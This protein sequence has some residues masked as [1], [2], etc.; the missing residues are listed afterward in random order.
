M[1]RFLS[2][3]GQT[4]VHP[5]GISKVNINELAQVGSSALGVVGLI[6]EADGGEPDT[7]IIID[8]PSLAKTLFRSGPLADAIRIVFD[9]SSDSRVPGS[10][11]RVIAVKPNQSTQSTGTLNGQLALS[12]DGE[13]QVVLT[14]VDYGVHTDQLTW[15]FEQDVIDT[16]K[17]IATIGEIG[18]N[19]EQIVDIGGT[20]LMNVVFKGPEEEILVYSGVALGT[21]TDLLINDASVPAT[22]TADMYVRII[23]SP[24]EAS[25]VNEVRRVTTV[26]VGT[27]IA[28][29]DADAAASFAAVVDVGAVYEVYKLRLA[30]LQA[31]AVTN[32]G[33]NATVTLQTTATTTVQGLLESTASIGTLETKYLRVVS[34]N[35][36]GQIRQI[37]TAAGP[38]VGPI[39]LTLADDDL[40]TVAP[41]VNDLVAIVDVVTATATVTGASGFAT[42]WESTVDWGES[43]DA[44]GAQTDQTITLANTKTVADIAAALNGSL[45]DS[46]Q[47]TAGSNY[48]ATIGA[49]RSGTIAGA[50]QNFD[51]DD[52]NLAVDLLADTD[53]DLAN[54]NRF[55]DNLEQLVDAVNT[56][57]SLVTAAR[58]TTGGTA[59]ATGAGIPQFFTEDVPFILSGGAR[60]ISANSNWQT[61]FDEFLKHRINTVVPLISQDLSNEIHSSTATVASVHAQLVSHLD[62]AAGIGKSERNGIAAL[63]AA[64]AGALTTILNKA[65]SLNNFNCSLVFGQPEV[66]DVDGNLTIQDEWAHACLAA[67]MG[68]G[69]PIGEPLTYKYLKA[70]SMTYPSTVDV[71]DRTTSNQLQ[72][73]GVLFSEFI[74]GKGH[75]WVRDI[76]TY[77]IDDNLANTDRH[78]REVLNFVAYDLR[79]DIEDRFTGLR[80]LPANVASIKS[81]LESK[82]ANYRKD[83]VIVD[84]TDE[85]G[86]TVRAYAPPVVTVSGDIAVI[87]VRIFPVV[88]I[89]Y[90]TI[91]IFTQ[92]PVL[93]A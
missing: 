87:K 79:T 35:G 53:L 14:S 58:S 2:F 1:A 80:A 55:L 60:G 20:P 32:V 73:G 40:F 24:T 23:S 21:S 69:T 82:L 37:K 17:Y 92:L 46:G 90:Q 52:G 72:L 93:S 48:L 91:E 26:V 66:L 13:P 6:G 50:S 9:S 86:A 83:G 25:I 84:S 54:R 88:G 77:L 44:L 45:A 33:S 62:T 15:S 27:S 22:V 85:T 78:V 56:F 12:T 57:S 19:R 65:S 18:Q 7:A 70:N 36:Q 71:L 89:N 81:R 4:I 74:R 5:G 30:T 49:G 47:P 11:N 61:A 28:I 39:V 42:Q 59:S 67:G 76:T 41:A 16:T 63:K 34:V 75:R 10:A 43:V 29:S 51:F 3:N 31:T 8:D 64:G 38:G 68:A